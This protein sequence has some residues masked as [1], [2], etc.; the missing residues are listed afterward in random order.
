MNRR[1]FLALTGPLG[2]TV[3]AGCLEASSPAGDEGT[4][5]SDGELEP[6]VDGDGV[7]GGVHSR[8]AELAAVLRSTDDLESILFAFDESHH[9]AVAGYVEE[10]D[11]EAESIVF[12]TTRLPS[13]AHDLSFDGV[14]VRDDRMVAD[15]T[16]EYDD[17][18]GM[19]LQTVIYLGALVRVPTTDPPS[20]LVVERDDYT[21]SNRYEIHLE[22]LSDDD[23]GELLVDDER[24]DQPV[25]TDLSAVS[26][27]VRSPVQRA[28]EDGTH[29]LEAV[30]ESL[31]RTVAGHAYV[32]DGDDYYELS[33]TLP[34]HVLTA[35]TYR[36]DEMGSE[37]NSA[38]SLDL[39]Y[40]RDESEPAYEMVTTAIR[41]GEARRV[42]LPPELERVLREYDY[43]WRHPTYVELN[44]AVDD[45][46]APYSL[47]ATSISRADISAGLDSNGN[48][49]T[50]GDLSESA[51]SEVNAAL[52]SE[53]T[54][55]VYN[56]PALFEIDPVRRLEA[57]LDPRQ[58]YLVADDAVYRPVVT[59]AVGDGEW[60]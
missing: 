39:R 10:T 19:V 11:F 36:R 5:D 41:D 15:F 26:S 42:A 56:P 32:R 8:Y 48:L 35:E 14:S 33:G 52:E 6:L 40:I 25:I 60:H 24:T 43:V 12:Y 50:V 31:A 47:Q 4:D 13:P 1:R 57:E 53:R 59:D 55:E 18:A 34:T 3:A 27:T 45:P 2:G 49:T 30:P 20:L 28:I 23:L 17:E 7:S 54:H 22:P 29:E 16:D 21:T 51:R 46:G 37:L 44:V 9:D 58:S 38:T